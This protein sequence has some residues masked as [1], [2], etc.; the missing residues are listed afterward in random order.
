MDS[1]IQ[2]SFHRPAFPLCHSRAYLAREELP[3]SNEPRPSASRRTPMI[4]AMMTQSEQLVTYES[5]QLKN[6]T[7]ALKQ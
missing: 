5:L 2:Q 6:Q 7:S 1:A 4:H 3:Y